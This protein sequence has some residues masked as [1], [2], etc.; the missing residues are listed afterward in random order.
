MADLYYCRVVNQTLES[1]YTLAEIDALPQVTLDLIVAY[2][3]AL[4]EEK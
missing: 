3:E 2:A 1:R 4:A